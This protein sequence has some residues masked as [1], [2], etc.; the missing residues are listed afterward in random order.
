[1]SVNDLVIELEQNVTLDHLMEIPANTSDKTLTIRSAGS[2]KP[3]TFMH[4][5][6][7]NNLFTVFANTHLI[8]KTLLL[9]VIK[10]NLRAVTFSQINP[11]IKT[12]RTVAI[13]SANIAAIH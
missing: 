2:E 11:K 13:H 4:G 3:V 9:M 6:T 10:V 7:K 1:M 8:L 12:K 5:I